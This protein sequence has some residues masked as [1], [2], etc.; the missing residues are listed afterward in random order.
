MQ[1]VLEVQ[2]MSGE[3]AIGAG[4]RAAQEEYENDLAFAAGRGNAFKATLRMGVVDLAIEQAF[5]DAAADAMESKDRYGRWRAAAHALAID[6]EKYSDVP[7]I[8]GVCLLSHPARWVPADAEH[9]ALLRMTAMHWHHAAVQSLLASVRQLET[10]KT[11]ELFLKIHRCNDKGEEVPPFERYPI[12]LED[13]ITLAKLAAARAQAVVERV[14]WE[15]ADAQW[16][17]SFYEVRSYQRP[18]SVYDAEEYKKAWAAEQKKIAEKNAERERA[19]TYVPPEP[20]PE[21]VSP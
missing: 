18:I 11:L 17:F 14:G 2:A 16:E 10:E 7:T 19:E 21:Y 12:C 20:P 13:R 1:D 4:L 15:A 6:T 8:C 3:D 5:K 9:A